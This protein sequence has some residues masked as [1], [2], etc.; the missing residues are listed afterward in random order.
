MQIIV[1]KLISFQIDIREISCGFRHSLMRS[2]EGEVFVTGDNSKM[3]LGIDKK[4]KRRSSP[5]LVQFDH[6]NEKT[7]IA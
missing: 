1:P 4:I 5:S 2:V 3:Q 6:E 7:L